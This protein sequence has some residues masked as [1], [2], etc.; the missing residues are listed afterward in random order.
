[1]SEFKIGTMDWKKDMVVWLDEFVET[2][3]PYHY[4]DSLNPGDTKEDVYRELMTGLK[5]EE[6]TRGMIQELMMYQDEDMVPEGMESELSDRIK[7]LQEYHDLIDQRWMGEV[8]TPEVPIE[9]V[10][11]M[12]YKKMEDAI[13]DFTK[14]NPGYE[15]IRNPFVGWE[16]AP[17]SLVRD[18]YLQNVGLSTWNTLSEKKRSGL[19]FTEVDAVNSQLESGKDVN[20]MTKQ[21]DMFSLNGMLTVKQVDESLYPFVARQS[22]MEDGTVNVQQASDVADIIQYYGKDEAIP[23]IREMNQEAIP[24]VR[25]YMQ[26]QTEKERP[27]EEYD[28]QLLS[29]VKDAPGVGMSCAGYL[30]RGVPKEQV[31]AM[32]KT[33][34][35]AFFHGGLETHD[36]EQ[37]PDVLHML[38]NEG[39]KLTSENGMNYMSSFFERKA[40]DPAL[41][42]MVDAYDQIKT[43]AWAD[44]SGDELLKHADYRGMDP[45]AVF[46]QTKDGQHQVDFHYGS[47]ES[48]WEF[49]TPSVSVYED[50]KLLYRE[51][52]SCVDSYH[53]E[54]YTEGRFA[55]LDEV[56]SYLSEKYPTDTKWTEV[57][58]PHPFVESPTD[59]DVHW[60]HESYRR[61]LSYQKEENLDRIVF[62]D[63]GVEPG[64]DGKPYHRIDFA[65]ACDQKTFGEDPNMTNP[66][67]MSSKRKY[68]DKTMETTHSYYLSDGVYSRLMSF[69]NTEGLDNSKWTGVIAARV[70]YPTSRNGKQKVSVNLTNE[71]EQKGQIVTPAVPFDEAKHD[72][73]IKRS[74]AAQ[75]AE[76]AK[77]AEAVSAR[78]ETPTESAQKSFGE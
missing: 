51:D 10:S 68:M 69:A 40:E 45:E 19:Y 65:Y 66:Y 43:R 35:Y 53:M 38:H 14:A 3:D 76:R 20:W 9:I 60:E 59:N 46:L 32:I 42:F 75:F 30:S 7:E 61:E 16:N 22:V 50:G 8:K 34:N 6:L 21:K 36:V 55:T 57:K 72:K 54:P 71:A 1:M 13:Q 31:D 63:R 73:F 49:F 74:M 18:A 24:G 5:D 77:A 39:F 52:S 12:D 37:I 44:R 28:V 67:L 25:W 48:G 23:M 17:G 41:N 70:T 26:L 33:A 29:R 11:S 15:G 64:R 58:D 47:R 2:A 62:Q 56:R 78:V 4:A 27:I